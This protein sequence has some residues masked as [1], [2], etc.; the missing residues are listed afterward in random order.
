MDPTTPKLSIEYHDDIVI[1]QLTDERILEEADIQSL[2]SA[3]MPVIDSQPNL[4]LLLDFSN[5]KYLSSSVLG[6]LIRASKKIY[7]NNGQLKLCSISPKI[8]EVFKITRLNKIFEI[9]DNQD[10]ALAEF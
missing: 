5:V 1:A 10:Q 7:E 4:K 2:E 9:Y 3:L 8:M 6:L